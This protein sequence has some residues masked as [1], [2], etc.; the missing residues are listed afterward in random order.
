MDG[1]GR[2]NGEDSDIDGDGLPNDRDPNAVAPNDPDEIL[3]ENNDGNSTDGNNTDTE[4]DPGSGSSG[5]EKPEQPKEDDNILI[6]E[7]G[8]GLIEESPVAAW[9]LILLLIGA[10]MVGAWPAT[11]KLRGGSRG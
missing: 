8:T 10:A 7:P 6:A 11:A 9:F 2:P 1:D 3:P 4:V 5:G